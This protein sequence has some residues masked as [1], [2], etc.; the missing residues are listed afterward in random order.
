[1]IKVARISGRYP[2]KMRDALARRRSARA[3]LGPLR[4]WRTV[5]A[6]EV[7]AEAGRSLIR[8]LTRSGPSA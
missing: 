3:E 7:G 2:P 4:S 5:G 1:M 6:G 8:V